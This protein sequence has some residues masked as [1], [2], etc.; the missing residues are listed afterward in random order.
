[1]NTALDVLGVIILCMLALGALRS[2]VLLAIEWRD[3]QREIGYGHGSLDGFRTGD[4]RGYTRG[5]S[6]ACMDHVLAAPDEAEHYAA[7]VSALPDAEHFADTV[8]M[9]AVRRSVQGREELS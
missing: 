6:Q 7:I 9:S 4:A 8:R 3:Y 2:L 5:Y 1:M